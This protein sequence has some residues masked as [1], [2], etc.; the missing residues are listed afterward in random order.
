MNC[1]HGLLDFSAHSLLNIKILKYFM[2]TLY[3]ALREI[4]ISCA[5]FWREYSRICSH[6]VLRFTSFYAM[7]SPGNLKVPLA[8]TVKKKRIV[9]FEGPPEFKWSDLG[10]QDVVGQGSFGAVF[11]VFD[12]SG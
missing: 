3:S 9:R 11:M 4:L 1:G 6:Y 8:L 10:E 12:S 2:N 5:L 7:L